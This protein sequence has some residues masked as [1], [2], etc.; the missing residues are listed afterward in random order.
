MI[1]TLVYIEVSAG[2]GFHPLLP[3]QIQAPHIHTFRPDQPDLNFS[4]SFG[5]LISSREV[6]GI[7][8]NIF[9]M[10]VN[11]H[12]IRGVDHLG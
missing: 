10:K 12:Q 3:F 9:V 5:I 8:I 6:F 2:V 1:F 11:V 7:H 4:R